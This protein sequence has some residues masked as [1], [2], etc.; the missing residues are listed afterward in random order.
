MDNASRP[1]LA[2]GTRLTTDKATG[3]PV[4]LF[5][6]GVVH[7]SATAEAI[8]NRCTGQVTVETLVKGLAEEFE[9]DEAA[10]RQDVLECLAQ[11]HQRKLVDWV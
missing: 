2:R 11:L 4:L 9:A 8:L 5:P 1:A 7:L 10:L 3:Q 6:E